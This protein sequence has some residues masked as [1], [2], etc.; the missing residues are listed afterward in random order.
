[1]LANCPDCTDAMIEKRLISWRD[2]SREAHHL[3]E[4]KVGIAQF[5]SPDLSGSLPRITSLLE[6]GADVVLLPEKWMNGGETNEV[7]GESDYLGRLSALASE[8]GS[9]ILSGGMVERDGGNLHISC[10]AFGR[11]GGMVAHCRKLHP[12]GIERRSITPG[13]AISHF[14]ID[15]IRI[16]VA[17][18]YDLDFPETVRR[19][20]MSGCDMIAVP[21]KI[22]WEGIDPWL[23]Y[24][25]A[26]ALENRM[27]VAFANAV[28]PPHFM[29]RSGVVD[30]TRSEDGMM[31]FP[32]T[33]LLGEGEEEG[34]F[35]IDPAA[36]REDRA[37]RLSERNPHTDA[38]SGE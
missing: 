34:V 15:G 5:H 1:M 24:L 30:L 21:A 36:Y 35:T 3:S 2:D 8:Y 27:P 38:L 11:D 33:R 31:M 4:M 17:I 7:D 18:C 37:S 12:F 20:A 22:R 25:Q 10:Y 28:S 29:G 14:D 13:R 16:G 19:F 26:R 23:I 6:K 9:V 32:R